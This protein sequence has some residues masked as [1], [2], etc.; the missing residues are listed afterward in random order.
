MELAVI[1]TQGKIREKLTMRCVAQFDRVCRKFRPT[2]FVYVCHCN[3]KTIVSWRVQ[4]WR[5]DGDYK[6]MGWHQSI[7]ITYFGFSLLQF[8]QFGV[9]LLLRLECTRGK[10]HI[11]KI[12][13][14][15]ALP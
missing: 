11:L 4:Q 5:E 8:G 6:A 7:L 12:Y 1:F 3:K 13:Y 15:K 14:L 2:L 10:F 9:F